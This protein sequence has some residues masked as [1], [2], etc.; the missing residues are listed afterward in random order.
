MLGHDKRCVHIHMACSSSSQLYSAPQAA[1]DV[2]KRAMITT[3]GMPEFMA[4]TARAGA[5]QNIGKLLLGLPENNLAFNNFCD[6]LV[7]T[8]RKNFQKVGRCRSSA[9]KRERLWRAFH[10]QSVEELPPKWKEL[11]TSLRLVD[12]DEKLFNQT[13]NVV[14][15]E[16]LLKQ[17]FLADGTPKSSVDDD[18]EVQMSKDEIN[19]L[20]YASGYVP[21]KL[22]KKYEKKGKKK[23]LGEKAE[24]FEMC[25]GNMAVTSEETDFTQYTSEWFHKVNR[26]GL[27]PVNDETLT[28]FVAVEKVTRQHLPQQYS[29]EKHE[30]IKQLVIKAISEDCDVQFY[31]TLISQ[32]IDEEEH[33]IELLLDIADLWVTIRGFSLA[34]TWLEEYKKLKKTKVSKRRGLRKDLYRKV[35]PP[36]QNEGHE[37]THNQKEGRDEGEGGEEDEEDE[38]AEE[39]EEMES[40]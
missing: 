28:F 37:H 17:H 9:T 19:A 1:K 6:Y 25:L 30:N 2:V 35:N 15:Y 12:M 29:S 5:V 24:Q 21:M 20:R 14:V 11:Y 13:V 38:I 18:Q 34:S 26:G 33:A 40:H 3:L 22:L 23:K 32:D 4:T 36:A 16:Q 39:E 31:W 8:L 10:K 7:G 27:F